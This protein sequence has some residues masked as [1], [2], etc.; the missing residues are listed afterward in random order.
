MGRH[1]LALWGV[2]QAAP[3]PGDIRGLYLNLA[4]ILYDFMRETGEWGGRRPLRALAAKGG[5]SK[6]Q[7]PGRDSAVM[8]SMTSAIVATTARDDAWHP[9]ITAL[10]HY[11]LGLH[12]GTG[13]PGRQHVDP[14]AVAPLLP[15]MFMVD[16]IREPV[17]FRYRLVGTEY[18][19]L[20]GKDLTGRYL[21]EVHPGFHGTVLRQYVEAAEHGRPAYRK[22][23]VLYA[24]P[25][26]QY[27]GM[28][29]IIV[30]LARNGTEVDI[31]LGAV[32]YLPAK[33]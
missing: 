31:L 19:R 1:W 11:W 17:R 2:R 24:N 13:L 33:R 14:C 26:R 21:D 32:V 4:T 15:H 18:V 3:V 9:T 27:L 30:P 22:G 16:V 23:P 20:I 29:R 28:E 10:Y 7:Y 5:L 12:P 25:E 6:T 8:S